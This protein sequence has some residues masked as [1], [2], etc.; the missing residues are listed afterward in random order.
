MG[1]HDPLVR[2]RG[3][4][5]REVRAAAGLPLAAVAAGVQDK[6]TISRVESGRQRQMRLSFLRAVV[7]RLG[8]GV[9]P[10]VPLELWPRVIM[11][12]A[13]GFVHRWRFAE[14]QPTADPPRRR[15]GTA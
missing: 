11:E 14:V 15:G 5:L 13:I 9:G 7:N 12:Q 3:H 2:V 6:S 4:V 10:T 1:Q 8:G